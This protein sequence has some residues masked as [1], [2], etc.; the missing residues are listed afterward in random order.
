MADR[1]KILMTADTVGGVWTYAVSLCKALEKYNTEVH[2][3][4]MG[5]RP[6]KQQLDQIKALKNVNLHTS[7]Y[8]LEWMENPWED[9]Q[10]AAIWIRE[11]YEQV[12]P[13]IIHFNNYGQVNQIWNCPVVTVFHSC[14]QTWWEAV[15]KENLPAEWKKYKETVKKALLNSDILIAPSKAILDQA[16]KAYGKTGFSKVIYNGSGNKVYTAQKKEPFILTA[17]RIWDEAKNI[18]LLSRIAKRL[19]WP[20]YVAGT[21]TDAVQKNEQ[22]LQN[23]Y[24]L[25]Q[26]SPEALQELMLKAALFVMPA[27]YE[28]FGLAILEAAR[29]GCT[30][31]LGNISTLNEIWEET[32]L[33]FDPFNDEE[34]VMVLQQLIEDNELRKQLAEKSMK[35]AERFTEQAMAANYFEVYKSLIRQRK[36]QT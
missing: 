21:A 1:L 11:V 10:Q 28:P 9:V 5:G 8:K 24:F 16:H 3:M 15:K 35:R 34:A 31:V 4:T 29:A 30:L 26:L 22:E 14:V 6:V 7:D 20:V 13:D 33:Y 25:G 18:S 36:L 32:A 2:L 19:K 12:Q 27:K 23:I 17:G